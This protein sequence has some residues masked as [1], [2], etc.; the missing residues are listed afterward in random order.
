MNAVEHRMD[1]MSDTKVLSHFTEVKGWDYTQDRD[2]ELFR[3][4]IGRKPRGIWLS[5]EE[6][7]GWKEWC[8]SEQFSPCTYEHKFDVDLRKIL[9][10][11]SVPDILMFSAENSAGIYHDKINWTNT[12]KNYSG[13]LITPYQWECRLNRA[14]DWYYGWDCA[15]GCFWDLSCLTKRHAKAALS[16]ALGEKT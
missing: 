14:C 8:H 3:N 2:Y 16:K 13:I 12:V 4:G 10:L 1:K 5:D 6:D 7:Y 9:H 15:S 11:K